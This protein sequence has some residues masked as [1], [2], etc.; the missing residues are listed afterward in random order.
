MP[1]TENIAEEMIYD[2]DLSNYGGSVSYDDLIATIT[3]FQAE[4]VGLRVV[5]T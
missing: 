2:A 5:I 3:M 4:E 1:I